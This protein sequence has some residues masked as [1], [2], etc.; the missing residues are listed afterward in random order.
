MT[1][2]LS[3]IRAL[4]DDELLDHYLKINL[5]AGE[6]DLTDNTLRDL[7]RIEWEQAPPG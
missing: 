4:S 7:L 3:A 5:K 1:K 6:L 2:T